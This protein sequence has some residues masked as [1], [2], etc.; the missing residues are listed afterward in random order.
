MGGV[1]VVV[2]VVL[3][4]PLVAEEQQH[5][6]AAAD[7]QEVGNGAVL[8]QLG[9]GRALD[10]RAETLPGLEVPGAEYVVHRAAIVRDRP[11]PV[12]P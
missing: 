10:Q 8:P 1:I 9:V 11:V 7:G 5:V 2:D 12:G 6:L 3:A 4:A